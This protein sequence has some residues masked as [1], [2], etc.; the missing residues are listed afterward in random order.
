MH[1][2]CHRLIFPAKCLL[3]INAHKPAN[4][5]RIVPSACSLWAPRLYH[6]LLLWWLDKPLWLDSL[7][8]LT[9]CFASGSDRG[10]HGDHHPRHLPGLSWY[11]PCTL[12]TPVPRHGPLVSSWLALEWQHQDSHVQWDTPVCPH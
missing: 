12:Q 9:R 6:N 10:A 5:G 11:M 8:W 1:E 3:I 7:S 4:S 2:K